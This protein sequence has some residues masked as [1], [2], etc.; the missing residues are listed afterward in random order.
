MAFWFSM[1]VLR[2]VSPAGSKPYPAC[3][4][5]DAWPPVEAEAASPPD[6]GVGVRTW[7]SL[8][9]SRSSSSLH[10]C[11][12]PVAAWRA[13][14]CS[15]SRRHCVVLHRL[16][17]SDTS[18]IA[19]TIGHGKPIERRKMQGS[20]IV[21]AEGAGGRSRHRKSSDQEQWSAPCARVNELQ[22]AVGI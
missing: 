13:S 10:Q 16:D 17:D 19:S 15:S 18:A 14:S 20:A 4:S 6:T 2:L 1:H 8:T 21:C 3:A 11:S 22:D 9:R 12:S 5:S 7:M